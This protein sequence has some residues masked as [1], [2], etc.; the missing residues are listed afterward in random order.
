MILTHTWKEERTPT[1]SAGLPEPGAGF[2]RQVARC[3]L[4]VCSITRLSVPLRQCARREG[5]SGLGGEGLGTPMRAGLAAADK[6]CWAGAA[7]S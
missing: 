6:V 5:V 7:A 4:P 1:K 3:A 2:M